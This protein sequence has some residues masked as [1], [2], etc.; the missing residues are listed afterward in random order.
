MANPEHVEIVKQGAGAIAEWGE[1]NREVRL[2][3]VTADLTG[4]FD[5]VALTRAGVVALGGSGGGGG[6]APSGGDLDDEIPF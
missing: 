1:E 6:P 3:L 5:A 4:R 2:N